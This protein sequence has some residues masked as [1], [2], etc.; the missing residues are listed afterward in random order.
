MKRAFTLIEL[1]VV[2]A[3]IAIL[4]AI[5]FP[6]FAQ[7]KSAAKKTVGISNFKQSMTAAAMYTGDSDGAHMLANSGELNS[8]CWGCGANG[9]TVPYQQMLPY[10]KN[11]AISVDPMDPFSERQRLDDHLPYMGANLATSTQQQRD[12]SL[13]VRANLGYNYAFFSPWVRRPNDPGGYY[14]GSGS[15]TEGQVSN[16]ANTLMFAT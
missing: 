13:G 15:T 9:D 6:V 2:I 8:Y 16:P 12:Y 1:L 3:I 4:A 10:I 14:T 5:L 11:T 7:A